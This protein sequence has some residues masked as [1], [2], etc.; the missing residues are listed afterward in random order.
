MVNFNIANFFRTTRDTAADLLLRKPAE[1][2]KRKRED[3]CIGT[4]R[5]NETGQQPT[6]PA[7]KRAATAALMPSEQ[8]PAEPQQSQHQTPLDRL[9]AANGLP[10]SGLG[11]NSGMLDAAAALQRPPIFSPGF[12]SAP[13]SWRPRRTL[14]GTKA[15][16]VGTHQQPASA[17][18]HAASPLVTPAQ[19]T[20]AARHMNGV[21]P[22]DT[23]AAYRHG[24]RTRSPSLFRVHGPGQR[25][26]A[27]RQPGT[28]ML[29]QQLISEASQQQVGAAVSAHRTL[30]LGFVW[31]RA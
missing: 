18:G 2:H 20:A 30:E 28:S 10:P 11:H 29:R 14:A 4:S 12:Y 26:T 7:A 17:F 25:G 15:T 24:T 23:A 21:L 8:A 22:P 27:Q 1:N 9:H 31:D 6:S 13:R 19:S 16:A 5:H 3:E